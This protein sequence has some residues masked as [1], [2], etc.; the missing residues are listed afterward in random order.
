MACYIN[1]YLYQI[2]KGFNDQLKQL[3]NNMYFL[4]IKNRSKLKQN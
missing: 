1:D 4:T 3:V 2:S